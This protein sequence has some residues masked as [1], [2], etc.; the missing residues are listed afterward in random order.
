MLTFVYF[1]WYNCW[2]LY[3]ISLCSFRQYV[4]ICLLLIC[5][6]WCVGARVSIFYDKVDC[7]H[8]AIYQVGF[9]GQNTGSK[10]YFNYR[11]LTDRGSIRSPYFMSRFFVASVT[12]EAVYIYVFVFW[13]LFSTSFIR[14]CMQLH[15][16]SNGNFLLIVAHPLADGS[17]LTPYFLYLVKS[18]FCC[19]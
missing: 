12:K 18:I 2:L 10:C 5:Y 14:Y 7:N 4:Y 9:P 1:Y 19:S 13:I 15:I 17:N 8:Q 3:L 11:D 16:C 6:C